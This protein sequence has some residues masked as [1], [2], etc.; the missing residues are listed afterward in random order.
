MSICPPVYVWKRVLGSVA[1]KPES[2]P[3]PVIGRSQVGLPEKDSVP[4]SCVPVDAVSARR[5]LTP[6]LFICSVPR[7]AF[8]VSSFAGIRLSHDWQSARKAELRPRSLHMLEPST[9]LPF[10]R[11]TPPSEPAKNWFGLPGTKTTACWS[12]CI[13]SPCGSPVMSFQVAPAS[14]DIITERPFERMPPGDA[15]GLSSS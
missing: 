9:N 14:V 13:D 10:V 1:S 6:M 4:L 12:G 11:T 15:Y 8:T 3:S 7:P 2:P 5:W